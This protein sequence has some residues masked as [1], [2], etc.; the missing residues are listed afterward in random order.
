MLLRFYWFLF[1]LVGFSLP[2][3]AADEIPT[4]EKIRAAISNALPPLNDA[5]RVSAEQRKCFTCHSQGL[6][7]LVMIRARDK[8]FDIDAENL[9]RQVN[10][11]AT[12]L[13]RGKSNYLA[14][15]GQGGKTDTA[16][17]A[18]WALEAAD[19]PRDDITDAVVEFFLKRNADTPYWSSQSKR[20]PSEGSPF[21]STFLA[22]R[23]LEAYEFEEKREAIDQRRQAA[24]DWLIKT[25]PKDNE[26][27][28]F[29]LRALSLTTPE[30]DEVQQAAND[31][32][33]HQNDDGSW[34]QL[35]DSEHGDAY[36]TGSAIDALHASGQIKAEDERYRRG[37][38]FLVNTQKDDGSWHVKSRSRPI[39]E[40]YD[41]GFPHGDDQFI[42]ASATA[43]A[44]LA[45][46]N[47][48]TGPQEK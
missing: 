44:T 48:L 27:R 47:A 24:L 30:S 46:L 1:A 11:T 33:N 16:G 15:I 23:G 7:V 38:G 9:Q 26:D 13:K 17:S 19:Y 31:L 2:A 37:V 3:F 39:Q 42:S 41:A 35:A 34:S 21:T 28:V 5:A 40:P 6:P 10:H 25:K 36:A 8:G 12:H 29:R 4:T 43:W 20:P 32:Q 14:G 22:L 18:L 45:L